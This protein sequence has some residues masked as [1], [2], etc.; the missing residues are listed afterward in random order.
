MVVVIEGNTI[1]E[2]F[3]KTIRSLFGLG[4]GPVSDER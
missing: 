3:R 2:D 1:K 4:I